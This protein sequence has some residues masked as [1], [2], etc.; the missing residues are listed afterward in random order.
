LNAQNAFRGNANPEL[1]TVGV[2]QARELARLFESIDISHIFCSDRL[3]ATKTAEIMAAAKNAPV[4]QSTSLRA[5][6]VGEFSGELR[7]PESE[8]ALQV[9]LDSPDEQIPGGESLNEFKSRIVPCIQE[10]IDIYCEC[11]T[12]S[13]IVAHSSVVHEVG[14]LAHGEHK[15]VLV[16][17]GGAIAVYVTNGKLGAEPIFKPIK[18]S[19]KSHAE[20][21]T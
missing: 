15:S 7:T 21:I 4:H 19:G 11:G 9:Y 20:T 8:A 2:K 10:A 6:D 14:F 17:P 13:L 3:R 5:L 18:A 1:D 12:P 16:E